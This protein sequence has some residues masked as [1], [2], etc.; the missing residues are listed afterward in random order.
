MPKCV[1]CGKMYGFPKG[2]T[3]VKNDGNIHHLCSAKCRKNMKMGRRKVRW[4]SKLKKT[5]EDIKA[6]IREQTKEEKD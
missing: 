6:E 5:K 4:I 1:F 3:L 2:L